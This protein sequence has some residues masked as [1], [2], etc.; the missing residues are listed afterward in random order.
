MFIIRLCQKTENLWL[1]LSFCTKMKSHLLLI[2]KKNICNANHLLLRPLYLVL[3]FIMYCSSLCFLTR[4][5]K[6][7]TFSMMVTNISLVPCPGRLKCWPVAF[8]SCLLA[9]YPLC[10]LNLSCSD[11]SDS[12]IY[13]TLHLVQEMQYIILADL[14]LTEVLISI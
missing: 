9:T 6:L 5:S 12:P 7:W 2:F 4:G 10:S 13:C 1:F 8:V 3:N 11:R 14:Q